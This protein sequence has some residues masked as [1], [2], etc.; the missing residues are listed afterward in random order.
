M[1]NESTKQSIKNHWFLPSRI[2]GWLDSLLVLPSRL[3]EAL[4]CFVDS[5]RVF[6]E[7]CIRLFIRLFDP[8][9]WC[10][11]KSLDCSYRRLL[12][13]QSTLPP[14]PDQPDQTGKQQPGKRQ[15]PDQTG[16]SQPEHSNNRTGPNQTGTSLVCVC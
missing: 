12:R 11:I 9:S 6:F 13:P 16:S 5:F 2:I 3:I 7:N 15:Q 10:P 14:Q 4:D 8:P 1:S